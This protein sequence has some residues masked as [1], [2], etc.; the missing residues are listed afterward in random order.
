MGSTRHWKNHATPGD[1]CGALSCC[2]SRVLPHPKGVLLDSD[3]VTGQHS[4]P[5]S[6]PTFFPKILLVPLI[7]SVI[8][9][10]FYLKNSLTITK[11]FIVYPDRTGTHKEIVHQET[12]EKQPDSSLGITSATR[13]ATPSAKP[14]LTACG[15]QVQS[16]PMI[17]VVNHKAYVISSYVEHRL[18]SKTIRTVAI[19]FRSEQVQ[20]YCLLCCNGINISAAARLDIHSD[21]FEFDYGTADITCQVP[22]T[23]TTPAYVAITSKTH[24]WG[25]SVW[26]IQSFQ[27]VG[28]QQPRTENFAYAF[29]VCI[30]VMYDYMNVL[31]LVQAMEMF[32]LL[33]VQKVAIYKTS[34]YPDTQ[35][36]LD[37][38]VRQGF[39]D[40]I[41]WTVS[42]YIKVARGW[43][44]SDSPGELEFFGQIVALNDCVYR[45]M[46][47]S[48]YVAL[49]DLDE[50]ILPLKEDN[51]TRLI[52]QLE[53][54]YQ[55]HAGFEFENN[56][57]PIS[58]S[59]NKKP[60]NTPGFWKQF[61]GENILPH[62]YRIPNDP[63][64]FNNFKVI[65]NPRLVFKATVHGV[66]DSAS[67]TV[68]V[69]PKIARMY[70]IKRY[71][72]KNV[73]AN[74]VIR[75]TRLWDYVD[76]LIPAVSEVLRQ[77]LNIQ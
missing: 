51:W 55:H 26:N 68:R 64:V 54:I 40:I 63:N 70:H 39:V 12:A 35:K 24:E 3:L 38:Y 34:C 28:N 69:D 17:K 74:S 66:L 6:K 67:G 7:L 4:F 53:K 32:K 49:Q 29:T 41:P 62:V 57:F 15:V 60:E 65:V 8:F 61:K 72:S 19:V 20:Y 18:S 50:L 36:V 52:P 45:Y 31:G 10:L 27:P 23:C 77:A 25:R 22:T 73:R 71:P 5:Q 42:S 76:K 46:Y 75:D 56:V 14:H 9:I 37:Y 44:K 58:L 13:S 43:K 21:H 1:F 59:S 48:Q 47:E 30:S 2:K 16:G 11:P 33:G